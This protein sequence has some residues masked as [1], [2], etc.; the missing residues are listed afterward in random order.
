VHDKNYKSKKYRPKIII[1]FN[2]A[3]KPLAEKLCSILRAGKVRSKPNVGHVL[4]QILAKEEVIKIINLINGHMRTPKIEAL[5]RAICWI[6]ENDNSSID[7]LDLDLSPIDSN[8]WLAGFSDGE[9][10]FSITL[11]DRKK[12]GK[13]LRT[14]MQ[15]FFRIEVKQNSPIEVPEKQGGSS[16]FYILFFILC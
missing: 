9:V 4:C 6:N 15:T 7:C 2:L 12:N 3:D 1:V 5:H 16:Y 10:N 11:C 8:S 13:V 14:N